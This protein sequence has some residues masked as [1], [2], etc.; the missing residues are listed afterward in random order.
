M[1]LKAPVGADKPKPNRSNKGAFSNRPLPK[2]KAFK[3]PEE[4][5]SAA[6][7]KEETAFVLWV[8]TNKQDCDPDYTNILEYVLEG[9]PFKG[10]AKF[11]FKD[12]IKEAGARWVPNPIKVEGCTNK[13]IKRGWWTAWDDKV[14]FYLLHMRDDYRQCPIWTCEGKDGLLVP[15]E[16]LVMKDWLSEF[17]GDEESKR[18][19][20]K[21]AS[22][23]A[24]PQEPVEGAE[25]DV[26]CQSYKPMSPTH[27]LHPIKY[28]HWPGDTLCSQC[29]SVIWDQFLD[30]R[31][32]GAKWQTCSECLVK[33]R[34]DA[35][36]DVNTECRCS[37]LGVHFGGVTVN[38]EV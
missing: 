9:S 25:D 28:K 19:E 32:E 16:C 2:R 3:P 6:H 26:S 38:D 36:A 4:E 24:P 12:Q 22:I 29:E 37:R 5:V 13:R 31:C 35:G 18:A 23:L 8:K 10:S 30:C 14:L 33:F 1:F 7:C 27:L 21:V 17:F 15:S 20:S 11:G 34:P